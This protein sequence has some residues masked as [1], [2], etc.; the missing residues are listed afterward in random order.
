MGTGD[1]C[2]ITQHT[3]KSIQNTLHSVML[4]TS[5]S[6]ITPTSSH[7]HH[8]FQSICHMQYEEREGEGHHHGGQCIKLSIMWCEPMCFVIS[9]P[10]IS[11]PHLPNTP[12]HPAY[13]PSPSNLHLLIK[14]NNHT[15]NTHP[16]PSLFSCV[17][18]VWVNGYGVCESIVPNG[19]SI[20][21]VCVS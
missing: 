15:H 2:D 13:P 9:Q 5:P 19:S 7:T 4:M 11:T 17:M 8:H 6:I 10:H 18:F 20:I 3:L 12:T 21:L 14:R 16:T 1:G